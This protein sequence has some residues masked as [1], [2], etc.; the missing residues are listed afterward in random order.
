M[1]NT[2]PP[3]FTKWS[4]V[5]W[6]YISGFPVAYCIEH[7]HRLDIKD[8]YGQELAQD[9]AV[10]TPH[11]YLLCPVDNALFKLNGDNFWTMRRR[12]T[13]ILESN[14]LKGATYRDLDNIYTPVLKI[15]PKP[16]DKR[17]SIQVEIDDTPQGKK[18]VIYAMDRENPSEKT[19]VFIDPQNDKITFDS[20]DLHPNMIFSRVVA[21]FKDGKSVSL[22]KKSE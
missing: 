19:Q 1:T 7:K 10:S 18:L 15:E 9:T 3:E 22:D 14:Q 5:L 16:K 2:T 17:Y 4:G 12:F 13:A 11:Q 20:N 6:K 21:Y 8:K